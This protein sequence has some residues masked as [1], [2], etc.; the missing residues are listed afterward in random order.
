MLFLLSAGVIF[1]EWDCSKK[2]A[3]KQLAIS[4][5]QLAQ[6]KAAGNLL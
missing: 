3:I 2:Q 5:S 6:L 4:N 1:W